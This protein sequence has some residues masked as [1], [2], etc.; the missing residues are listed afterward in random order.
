MVFFKK[1][2]SKEKELKEKKRKVYYCGDFMGRGGVGFRISLIYLNFSLFP[3]LILLFYF[4][5]KGKGRG[6]EDLPVEEKKSI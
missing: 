6:G 2:I 5:W 1:K 4:F 3:P